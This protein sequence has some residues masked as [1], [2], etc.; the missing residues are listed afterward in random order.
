MSSSSRTESTSKYTSIFITDLSTT[1]IAVF[2]NVWLSQTK[3]TDVWDIEKRVHQAANS[4]IVNNE[5]RKTGELDIRWDKVQV[6]KAVLPA[7]QNRL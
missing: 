3:R 1:K 4:A 6:R 2:S 5:D 7:F